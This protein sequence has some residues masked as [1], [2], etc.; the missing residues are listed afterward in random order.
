MHIHFTVPMFVPRQLNVKQEIWSLH[1]MVL[2]YAQGYL[3]ILYCKVYVSYLPHSSL[4]SQ[5]NSSAMYDMCP[6]YLIENELKH[7][8]SFYVQ[9]WKQKYDELGRWCWSVKSPKCWR[10][11]VN[12]QNSC[13]IQCCSWNSLISAVKR[14]CA[15]AK[16]S[17]LSWDTVTV[18]QNLYLPS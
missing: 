17:T 11:V 13:H 6:Y 9:L 4:L 7:G 12:C 8:F 16:K 1:G 3:W 14:R 5:L 10:A 15:I 18:M 2:T